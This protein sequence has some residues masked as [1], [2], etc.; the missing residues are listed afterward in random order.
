[1]ARPTQASE[2]AAPGPG[3]AADRLLAMIDGSWVTQAVYVAAELRIADLLARG[4]M[5]S[6]ALARAASADAAALRRLLRALATVEVVRELDDGSFELTP[7]G[8]RLRDDHPESVR[9][10]SVLIGGKQWPV[11]GNLLYSVRTGRS[12]RS[13]LTGTEGFGHLDK[14]PEWAALFHRAMA[15]QTRLIAPAVVRAYDFSPFRRVADVGGG[16]G[17]LLA[18]VLAASPAATG[19]LFDLPAAVEE[20]RHHLERAGLAARCEFIA[21]SFFES[22]PPGADAYLLKSIIHD[23]DDPPA[24]QILERCRA[25]M[26]PGARLLLVERVQPDHPRA[27]AA[28][29]AAARS[30]LNMLVA[31]AAKERTAVEFDALLRSAGFRLTRTVLAGRGHSVLEAVPF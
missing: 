29:Q 23:W 16:R 2:A 31:L 7:L 17:E 14:D 4:P 20:G 6:Q 5:D 25:A 12:A 13:M 28:D 21:G 8:E 3:D 15:E 18:H 24:R 11:W 27:T 1:M 10:W 19:V 22:V 26:P 30:D 9:G